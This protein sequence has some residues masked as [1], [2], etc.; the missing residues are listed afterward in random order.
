M[1]LGFL[2][3]LL[4]SLLPKRAQEPEP[5]VDE[6]N[7]LILTDANFDRAVG[8]NPRMLVQFHFT[9][10]ERCKSIKPLYAAV[11]D[12][13]AEDDTPN[14][15]IAKIDANMNRDAAEKYLQNYPDE[16]YPSM[17]FFRSGKV[18]SYQH[19]GD[20]VTALGDLSGP[21]VVRI[22]SEEEFEVIK[23]DFPFFL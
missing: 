3:P 15:T 20:F 14:I 13:F 17:K 1:L 7:V 18:I 4:Y 11:A 5:V 2:V 10:S 9:W 19:R 16:D 6:S 22:E 21:S 12:Y 8:D 23:K